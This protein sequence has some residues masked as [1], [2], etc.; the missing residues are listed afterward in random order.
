MTIDEAAQRALKPSNDEI[1]A[2]PLTT[3]AKIAAELL[4]G[5][6]AALD[7]GCGEGKFTRSLAALFRQVSGIDVKE[8]AIAK[9]KA[10]A[11]E[12]GVTVDFRVASAEA[13][14][15]PDASFD[16]VA[17]SNSL[18][19]IGDPVRAIG[20]ALRVLKPDGVLYVMEPVASGNYHDATCLVNDETAVRTAAYAALSKA[21]RVCAEREVMYRTERR[22]ADFDEWKA[23]QIDRDEKR[24]ARFDAQPDDVRRRFESNAERRDG[25]LVFNQCFRVNVLRKA[26]APARV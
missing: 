22:F 26:A 18:H 23:D 20:E 14:P 10:A 6:E 11:A 5:G 24:R 9:A 3:N 15:F 13:L 16:T 19:H 17:F 7:I 12:A 1:R 2:L 25:A 21:D 4:P 8:R